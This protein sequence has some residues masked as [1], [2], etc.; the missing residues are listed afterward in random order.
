MNLVRFFGKVICNDTHLFGSIR[1]NYAVTRNV[2]TCSGLSAHFTFHE[3]DPEPDKLSTIEHIRRGMTMLKDEV[4]LWKDEITEAAKTDPLTLYPGNVDKVFKFNDAKASESWIATADQDNKDGYS[5]CEFFIDENGKG[6]FQG[7]LNL[8]I[9]SDGERTRAGYCNLKSVKKRKSFKRESIFE[10]GMYTHLVLRV[11]GD[12]RS[13]MINLHTP[14]YYDLFWN[15]MY[16]FVLYTRGGPY[17]QVSKIPFSKFFLASKGKVQDLQSSPPLDDISNVSLTMVDRIEGPFKLEI[18]YI[19]VE[20]DPN[21]TEET[22][23]EM[24]QLPRGMANS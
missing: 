10:W 23:Y 14:G 12:G 3:P 21:H 9:P 20:L 7:F 17:W 8:K 15:D 24:Y 4:R 16:Q 13:Y 5:N 2:H 22:A 6:V 19:G 11:R 1:Q 18:D